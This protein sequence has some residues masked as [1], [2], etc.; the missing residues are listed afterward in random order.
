MFFFVK[1]GALTE[2]KYCNEKE[3]EFQTAYEEEKKRDTLTKNR[4]FKGVGMVGAE[5]GN[6]K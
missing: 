3:R 1:Q 2:E 5:I 6:V 4:S